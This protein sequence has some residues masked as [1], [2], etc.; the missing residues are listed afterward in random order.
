MRI[1]EFFDSDFKE[2]SSLDNVRSIPSLIDGLKDSQRKAVYAMMLHGNSEIKV[3]QF[4]TQ[5]ALLTHYKHG[6]TSM[7]ETVVNLAQNFAGSNNVNLFEPIGQ[8]GSILS[9]ESS[10]T[11][12][13]FTKPSKH[14]R[15]YFKEEDDCI[16][17]HKYEDSDKVEPKTLLPII[18]MWIVNGSIGVGTGHS[19]KILSRN[20]ENVRK[21][22]S[23][24]LS[25]KNQREST[26]NDLLKPH[27]NR[28]TGDIID[29]GEGKYELHGKI[30]VVNSTTLRV[31]ELPITYGVD[32]F[33]SILAE[34][35]QSSDVKDYDN[36][37]TEDGFDFE[38]KVPREVSRLS[39][40]ELKKKFKLI[41]RMTENITLW[42]SNGVL[43]RYKSVYDALCEFV[44]YRLTKYEERRLKHIEVLEGEIDFLRQKKLFILEW[45]SLDNPGKRKLSDLKEHMTR[46]GIKEENLDRLFSLRITS[47]TQDLIKELEDQISNKVS[48]VKSLESVSASDLYL[49]EI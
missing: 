35:I 32:K 5:A 42:D 46:K 31:T 6:E 3:S 28:W 39:I 41:Y 20:V 16:L 17:E 21:V 8:F 1:K 9:S 33:K 48:K 24:I 29:L 47:L 19:S 13:I 43:V 12:Y 14:L 30:E 18:P 27:F 25:N 40:D 11:R 10:A 22:I 36:N 49:S 2:F 34:L 26:I 23:A 15:E 44:E 37:S 38:I 7:G 4:A 45:N